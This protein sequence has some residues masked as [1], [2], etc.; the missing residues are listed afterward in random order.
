M[1]VFGFSIAIMLFIA[2]AS[3][4]ARA[5][6]KTKP[7]SVV[8]VHP[9]ARTKQTSSSAG[10]SSST[11]DKKTATSMPVEV[12]QRLRGDQLELNLIQEQIRSHTDPLV[13]RIN[14]VLAEYDTQIQ[15]VEFETGTIHR[16]PKPVPPTPSAT[17]APKSPST[18]S[19]TLPV[20]GKK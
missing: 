3:C 13:K 10:K 16:T 6:N 8:Q 17:A 19:Q 15:N 9:D 18:P 12:A 14:D 1:R 2:F 7:V 4:D 11:F 20:T 5:D